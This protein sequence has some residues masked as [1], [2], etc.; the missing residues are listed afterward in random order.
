MNSR[1]FLRLLEA[2]KGVFKIVLV[3]QKLL[4][5]GNRIVCWKNTCSW[6]IIQTE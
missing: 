4:L 2:L 3:A 5:V 6:H 1:S